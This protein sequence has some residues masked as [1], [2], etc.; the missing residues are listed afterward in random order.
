M[1]FFH[2][3]R[4]CPAQQ[5]VLTEATY[6]LVRLVQAFERI[7]NREPVQEYVEVPRMLTERRNNVKIGLFPER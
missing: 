1:L 5:Q 4:I 6:V 7:E 2:G 3:R